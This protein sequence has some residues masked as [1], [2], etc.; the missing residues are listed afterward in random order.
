MR[1]PYDEDD[2]RLYDVSR[3][4]VESP[5]G[6]PSEVERSDGDGVATFRIGSPDDEVSGRQTYVLT[7]T[8]DGAL[9]AFPD[10][11]ELYWNAIGADWAVPIG[12]ASAT[13]V[14]PATPTQQACFAG[15]QAACPVAT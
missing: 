14:G 13:V 8:V 12:A 5:T 3:F 10:H 4:D 2:D 9:N 6:A 1:V 15:P 11:D 7:Y